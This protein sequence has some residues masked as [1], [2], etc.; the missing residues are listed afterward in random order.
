MV[1]IVSVL[2][3]PDHYVCKMEKTPKSALFSYETALFC[4]LF[5]VCGVK[6]PRR[7]TGTVPCVAIVGDDGM[8]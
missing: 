2:K 4:L 6:L 7:G 3:L 8:E 5:E 1:P